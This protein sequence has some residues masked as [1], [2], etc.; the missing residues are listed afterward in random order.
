[1]IDTQRLYVKQ[2][3][4]QTESMTGRG[5]QKLHAWWSTRCRRV[6]AVR[7]TPG[8]VSRDVYKNTVQSDKE[9]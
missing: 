4:Q 6:H 8:H 3:V 7:S 9:L 5:E 1:M 2:N